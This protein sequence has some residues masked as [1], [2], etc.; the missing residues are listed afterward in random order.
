MNNDYREHMQR[1]LEALQRESRLRAY[2]A[3]LSIVFA[4]GCG[5]ALLFL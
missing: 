5:A 3:A 2:L 1:Q 4:I